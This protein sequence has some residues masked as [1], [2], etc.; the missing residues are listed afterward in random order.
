MNRQYRNVVCGINN[1]KLGRDVRKQF[2][3]LIEVKLLSV[4]N[5]YNLKQIVITLCNPYSKHKENTC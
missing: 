2:W 4:Y 5:R 1:I 3:Y